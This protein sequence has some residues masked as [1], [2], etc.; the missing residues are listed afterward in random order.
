MK[1]RTLFLEEQISLKVTLYDFNLYL[2]KKYLIY[3]L[4]VGSIFYFPFCYHQLGGT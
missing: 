1:G 2:K 4:D 3:Y